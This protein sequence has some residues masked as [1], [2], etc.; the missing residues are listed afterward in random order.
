MRSLVVKL[1]FSG[2]AFYEDLA[3]WNS[4]E[5]GLVRIARIRTLFYFDHLEVFQ[6]LEAVPPG[7]QENNVATL[8]YVA[9]QVL[10]FFAVEI[11]PHLAFLDEEDLQGVTHLARHG[12][13]DVRLNDFARRVVHVSQLLGKL[14][15]SEKANSL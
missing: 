13:V 1:L 8:Q 9:F 5:S 2:S 11:R 15:R 4:G 12:I 3:G 7:G 6:H 10:A 14:V